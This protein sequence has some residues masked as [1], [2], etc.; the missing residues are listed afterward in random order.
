MTVQPTARTRV[1]QSTPLFVVA[2]LERSIAFYC[3]RLGFGSA[4]R[5]GDPPCFAMIARD[6]FDLMLSLA[7]DPAQLTPNGPH[8]LWDLYLKVENLA[9]EQAA[10]AAAGVPIATAEHRTEYDMLEIEVIDPDGHRICFGQD[11]LEGSA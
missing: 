11:L 9:D 1:H 2:D 8:G 4:S 10:L 7:G 3:E 5:W 6:D